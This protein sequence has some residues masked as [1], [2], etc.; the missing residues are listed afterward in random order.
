MGGT[1]GGGGGGGGGGPS[2]FMLVIQELVPPGSLIKKG[3][4]VAEFD[5]VN[6]INRLDDFRA[7]LVQTEASLKRLNA[8]L[9][10]SRK[11]HEQTIQLAKAELDKARLD[12]QTTPVRSLIDAE[13]LKL[14]VQEAEARY[15]QLLTEVPNV[16]VV[17]STQERIQQIE[18]EQGRLELKRLEAHADRMLIKA[19]I[20]GLTVMQ[21]M[22]RGTEMSPIQ[23]G[24]QVFPGMRFMS[25]VDPSSMVVDA[26]VNQVDVEQMRVGAKA[27]VRFDAYPGL[28]MPARVIAVG[29]IPKTGGQRPDWVK[30]IPVRLKL[31]K[32]DTR[33]IPDLS[34]SVDVEIASEQNATLVPLG[35][36]F[37]EDRGSFVFLRTS[38]GWERR[39][40]E[41]GAA[42]HLVAAIR[43]GVEPGDVIAAE[44][45]L[46]EPKR[47]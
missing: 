17:E 44:W 11:A 37:H 33:V 16:R 20:N 23:Q 36:L 1:G 38:R 42:N 22:F 43:S 34:V 3:D 2:D 13:K 30:E 28:E 26:T 6:M 4:I 24:D 5:R 18:V 14:A 32:L 19:P 35:G 9:E 47:K 29:A 12:M 45:P 31:D 25:I 10:V 15:K 8:E 40:V 41:V 27:T 21:N 46:N 39:P 7:A